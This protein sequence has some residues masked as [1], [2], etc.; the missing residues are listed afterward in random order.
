MFINK[1]TWKDRAIQAE[2]RLEKIQEENKKWRTAISSIPTIPA[3]ADYD[4]LKTFRDKMLE[5][6][7]K[8]GD[9]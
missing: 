8:L 5:W 3:I 4:S 7:E 2:S 6:D 9:M 1:L